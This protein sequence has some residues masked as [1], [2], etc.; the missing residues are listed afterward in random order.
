[1]LSLECTL[2][3]LCTENITSGSP[4]QCLRGL[5]P[6]SQPQQILSCVLAA[7]VTKPGVTLVTLGFN[8]AGIRGQ[9][10]ADQSSTAVSESLPS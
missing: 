3:S 1:M 7:A 9:I 4:S 2:F 5:K 6:S 10:N 8:C